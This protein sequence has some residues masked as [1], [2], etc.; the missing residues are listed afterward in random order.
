[1]YTDAEGSGGLGALLSSE[2]S[3]WYTKGSVPSWLPKLLA[4]RKTQIFVYETLMVLAAFH[5]FVRQLQGRRVLVFI[6][7]TSA[8]GAIKK[9]SSSSTDVHALVGLLWLRLAAQRIWAVFRWVPSKLNLAD[10]PSRGRE[11]VSGSLVP[12]R[13]D[14]L[15]IQSALSS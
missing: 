3:Q 9:G 4:P 13:L 2:S 7:N 6:D 15:S 1:L 12:L 11:P 5:V 10:P 8:L 14:W